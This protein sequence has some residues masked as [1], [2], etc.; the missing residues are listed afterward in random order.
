VRKSGIALALGLIAG[1]AGLDAS[2][3]TG[4][5]AAFEAQYDGILKLPSAE[6]AQKE[7]AQLFAADPDDPA[8]QP[9]LDRMVQV[10]QLLIPPPA[11]VGATDASADSGDGGGSQRDS[12]DLP[13]GPY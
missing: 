13:T 10:A 5:A 12:T 6:A 9:A 7:L 4:P 11:P 2:A 8:V 1:A 3:S